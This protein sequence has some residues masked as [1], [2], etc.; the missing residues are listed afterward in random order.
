MSGAI[1]YFILL[2][3]VAVRTQKS[4]QITVVQYHKFQSS[5]KRQT[6]STFLRRIL[7]LLLWESLLNIRITGADW[8]SY[9][10]GVITIHYADGY[11]KKIFMYDLPYALIIDD[12]DSEGRISYTYEPANVISSP[13]NCAGSACCMVRNNDKGEPIGDPYFVVSKRSFGTKNSIR[14]GKNGKIG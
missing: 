13:P 2:F 6:M 11:E 10:N 5:T 4:V 12:V 7:T 14:F 1:Y 9:T 8:C 3:H